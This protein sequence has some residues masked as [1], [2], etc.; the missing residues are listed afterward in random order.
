MNFS[1]S[2]QNRLAQL[3]VWL[4]QKYPGEAWHQ[5]ATGSTLHWEKIVIVGHYTSAAEAAMI[6]KVQNVARV[7]FL[8]GPNEAYGMQLAEWVNA[9]HAT[10][11]TVIGHLCMKM[12]AA[13]RL[14]KRSVQRW[15]LGRLGPIWTARR[16]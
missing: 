4:D 6:A 8:G 3:L 15:D 7:I 1:N 9:T 5:F 2:V 11:R 16:C 12:M 10:K 13:L 14:S